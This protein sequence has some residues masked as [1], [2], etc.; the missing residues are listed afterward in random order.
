MEKFEASFES[1]RTYECPEW[2]RDAKF[3]IWSHWGPQSVPMY[4]D[5]YARYMYVEGSPQY[6]YHLRHYGHPS[7]FGY[8]DLAALWKAEKFDPEALMELYYK[9]GARYFVAQAMHHDHFFNY[10][11]ALHDFNAVKIG[12][13][14]DICMLWKQ[15]AEK[16]NL[17]FGLTEHL[18]AAFTWWRTNKW[19]DQEGAYQGIPYD[20]SDPANKDIYFD[21]AYENDGKDIGD[22]KPRPWYT[23]DKAFRAYWREVMHELIEKFEP[24]L[25]YTDGGLP[26][27]EVEVHDLQQVPTDGN[28]EYQLGLEVV[29]ELYNKSIAKYGENRAVYNQKDRRPE[30]YHVGILDIEKSQLP[31][32]L[33]DPWQTDTCI[34][35]WFYDVR[36]TFKTPAHIIEMLVDIVSK[37]GTMLLNILQR[38]DGSLDQEAIFIL[39]E[40]AKWFDVCGEGIHGTR[41]WKLACEG[42]TRVVIKRFEESKV[43]WTSGDIRYT[44]KGK[45]VFAFL[46]KAPENGVAILK[47]FAEERIAQV[48][49][50]GGEVVPFAHQFGVLSVQLPEVLPTPYVLGL[51]ITLVK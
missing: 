21:N 41:P 47:S 3:G 22:I 35:N 19:C 28:A 2:F 51:K 38:P 49:V 43:Q 27:A 42:E 23:Q 29:S 39:E 4:G 46:L 31:D 14:K 45:D 15:A 32:I 40:L 1:L 34:G 24:D 11:S 8:K 18:S 16:Y 50:M 10:D 17:P 37:N 7:E 12:P 36:E 9:A 20:G 44:Q 5:W 33:P 30:V 6:L 26:F 13:H 48:S 25:L